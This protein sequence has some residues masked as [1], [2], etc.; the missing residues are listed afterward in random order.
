MTI[1]RTY[2][3][4][5][6]TALCMLAGSCQSFL[7]IDLSPQLIGA[8]DVFISDGTARSAVDGLYTQLRMSALSLFN[9]GLA[10]HGGLMADELQPTV[11]NAQLDPFFSNTIP[12]TDAMVLSQYWRAAYQT[13]YRANA[14]I[15]QLE[16]SIG[17]TPAVKDRLM[18]EASFIRAFHY[19]YLTALF[20][21][22]PLVLTTD[23]TI[24]ASM[25][26]TPVDSVLA[27]VL[28]DLR[29]A[30]ALLP[31]TYEGADRIR[32]N[33]WAAMALLARLQLQLGDY[34]EAADRAGEVLDAQSYAL[35]AEPTQVF[36]IGSPETI[37][38]IAPAGGF[39]NTVEVAYFLPSGSAQQP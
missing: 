14:V 21:D 5:I 26:R 7:A 8:E 28:T 39:G 10:I 9:G 29:K 34:T 31:E 20:G 24:N 15:G 11:A 13:V 17:L 32:P 16:K 18:G 1:L 6:G 4:S 27:Q 30:Q 33:R 35:A 2:F 19:L 37:W 22:V 38:A 12:A 25:T 36:P 3:C 23:Y